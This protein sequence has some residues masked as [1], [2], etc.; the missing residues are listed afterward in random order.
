MGDDDTVRSKIEEY[1]NRDPLASNI[2]DLVLKCIPAYL[3]YETSGIKTED[4]LFPFQKYKET[5][6]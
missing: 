2:S 1:F 3:L 5:K 6:S 4:Y